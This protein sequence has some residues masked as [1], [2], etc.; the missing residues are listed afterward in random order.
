MPPLRT[1][2]LAVPAALLAATAVTGCGAS[3]GSPAARPAPS[4]VVLATPTRATPSPCPAP[5]STS[6]DWPKELPADLP[7]PPGATIVRV[8]KLPNGIV[9]VRFSDGMSLRE[10]VIWILDSFKRGGWVLGRGDA[11]PSEADQPFTRGKEFGQVRLIATDQPCLT[12]WLMYYGI[13][14]AP[15]QTAP[16]L[17]VYSPKG[18]ASALPFG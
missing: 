12:Q 15:S 13:R 2:L 5:P 16:P 14:D 8:D 10:G 18:P 9:G 3:G 7:K 6:P 17:P 4:S 1:R 11:E